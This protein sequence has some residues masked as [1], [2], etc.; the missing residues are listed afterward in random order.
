MSSKRLVMKMCS[1]SVE[2]MPSRIGL[3]VFRTQSSKIGAGQRLAGR[4]GDAQRRQVGAVVHRR[5]HRAVG[6]RRGEARPSPC[7]VSMICDHVRRRGAFE[8]RRGG[9]EAQREDRQPAEPEGEGERRRAD[10]DIV[11]RDLQ[12]LLG[13]A[14]GDDQQVAVEM[15]GRLRHA[16]GARSEAEQRHIVA[17]GLH[18][19][20]AHRL[21]ERERGRARRRGWRCRRSR[22]PLQERA[23]LGAGDHLVHQPR[24]AQREADLGLVD[25]LR[26]FA[27]AQ[28]RHGVDHHRRPPWWRPASR[29]PWPGCWP[30]GSVPGCRA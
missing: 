9:A 26:Q 27:G 19:L 16:G 22:P 7:T 3:P 17:A 8:Q 5:Q 30:S 24:V 4:D 28:H 15:H 12:H 18:R 25:D 21:V 2:P 20:E 11:G 29:P 14:V 1:I 10:E 23:V 6:G 13:V